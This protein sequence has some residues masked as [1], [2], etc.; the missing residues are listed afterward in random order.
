MDNYRLSKY[1]HFLKRKDRVIGIIEEKGLD[2]SSI[3]LMKNRQ[4]IFSNK[5][6]RLI[7]IPIYILLFNSF[8][9]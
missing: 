3:L 4:Q 9:L 5:S 7:I 6:Y 8:L 1:N 2:I